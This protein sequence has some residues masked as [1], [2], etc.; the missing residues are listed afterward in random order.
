VNERA[1]RPAVFLDRDGVLAEAIVRDGTAYAPTQVADFVLVS[2]AAEQVQRLREAGFLCVVFT[3]QPE[4][5]TGELLPADLDE[6]HRQM[7]AAIPLDDVF[8][9]PHHRSEGCRCYKPATGMIDDAVA[10]WDI[11]LARSYVIGDRWRDVDA[12]RAAGCYSILIERSYSAA[13]WAS[14]R[15]STLR[16][17]VDVVLQDVVLQNAVLHHAQGATSMDFVTRY[18]QEVQQV[19]AGIDRAVV[20]RIIELMVAVRDGGGRLFI[21]GVGGSAGNAGHAVNDFRKIASFEAYAPTDNVSELT[22]RINDDGWDTSFA[23]WLQ[24]SR[25]SSSDMLLVLSVGG[26]DPERNVS[27]NLVRAMEY[28]RQVGARITGIVGRDGGYTAKVADACVIVPVISPETVT[29]HSEAFQAVVWHLF[30]SD[31]RLQ[32]APM[33]WESL[34][35]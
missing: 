32:V 26:G 29:A 21:L 8:F 6:M 35:R 15:V 3:N 9:C 33:K 25:L 18:F 14:A 22:A 16:E 17:A 24:G 2:D 10:R 1:K 13:T 28:A 4:L 7:R 23:N 12:G 19:A 27:M 31:P 11:D 5:A 34:E 30:V 20:N